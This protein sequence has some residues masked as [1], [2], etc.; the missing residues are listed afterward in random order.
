MTE[1]CVVV[2]LS[3][4]KLEGYTLPTKGALLIFDTTPEGYRSAFNWIC[5][6]PQVK[7]LYRLVVPYA[8]GFIDLVDVL[9][10]EK[11]RRRKI[12]VCNTIAGQEEMGLYREGYK[13]IPIH[14][15]EHLES[16]EKTAKTMENYLNNTP[17]WP[18]RSDQRPI[19]YY[20]AG[21]LTQPELFFPR[22]LSGLNKIQEEIILGKLNDRCIA[23][24]YQVHEYYI[25]CQRTRIGRLSEAEKFLPNFL[26]FGKY[27]YDRQT[28]SRIIGNKLDGKNR[29]NEQLYI[30]V[31]QKWKYGTLNF[32]H[33]GRVI[34]VSNASEYIDEWHFH[35]LKSIEDDFQKVKQYSDIV[36]AVIQG[37]SRMETL[38][39]GKRKK[40]F[41]QTESEKRQTLSDSFRYNISSVDDLMDTP[42]SKLQIIEN[43]YGG[44]QSAVK[45]WKQKITVQ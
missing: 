23:A 44:I 33:E 45:A 1:R 20:C 11:E 40:F 5:C 31:N 13:I 35:M 34:T 15:A 43:S 42:L 36:S 22:L 26:L 17:K 21:Y 24:K 25:E 14:D 32:Y 29:D 2:K 7:P 37:G 41:Q 18:F 28:L 3:P 4:I 27:P 12:V 39:G 30:S 6:N 10:L 16:W 38:I 19:D 8:V 9:V